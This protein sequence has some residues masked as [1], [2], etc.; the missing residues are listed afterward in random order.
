[1]LLSIAQASCCDQQ[2]H[3][4]GVDEHASGIKYSGEWRAGNREGVPHA[5][6]VGV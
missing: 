3:R 1:M 5:P 4:S 6:S 2:L